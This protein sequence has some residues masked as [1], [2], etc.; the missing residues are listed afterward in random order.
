[1]TCGRFGGA[2]APF[3]PLGPALLL[4]CISYENL[5]NNPQ[6]LFSEKDGS[7]VNHI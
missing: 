3:A 1:M 2:C 7:K 5:H 6:N 4:F